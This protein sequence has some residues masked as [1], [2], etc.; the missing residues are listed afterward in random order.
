MKRNK[1]MTLFAACLM[2]ATVSAQ[3]TYTITGKSEGSGEK[4]ISNIFDD[5]INTKYC[6]NGGDGVYALLTASEP[7][8][9]W[10]YEMTTANDNE[11]YGRCIKKWSLFGTNDQAV[12]ADPNA[13]GW[14][15]LSDLGET[16]IVNQ[17]NYYTQRIFCEKGVN[18]P[19]KY[20]KVVLN[21]GN[22]IQLSE[23][24]IL[25]EVNRVV[26]Y[27]WK[28]SSQDNS[29]KAVDLLLNQKWEGSNIAGNWVTIETGDGQAYAVKSYSF[30]THDDG[31]CPGRAPKSWK[32]E[33]SNDNSNW[34]LIDEVVND[35]VI[36][37]ENYKTFDFTPANTTD[38]FR[39]IKL[40][41]NAMKGTGWTQ[42]GEFHV[43]STS[44]ISDAQYYTN[45]VNNAKATKTEY[46]TFMG[47]S[48]PWCVEYNTFFTG[49]NLDGELAAAISSGDYE[50]LEVKLKEAESNAIGQALKLFVNGANY[51]AI[52]GSECW[53]DGNYSQLFDN[54]E[55]TKWG[56]NNFPQYVIFRVKAAFKPFFYKLVTGNDT[57]NNTGRNWKSWNVYGANFATYK[58]ATNKDAEEWT[59]LDERTDVTEEYLPM[60]NFYP[61]TFDFNKGVNEDYLYYMVKVTAPHSGSQQQM[62]EMYL[63]TKEEFEAIRKPLVDELKEFATGVAD[64]VVESDLE[65][66]KKTFTDKFAELQTTSDAVAL[67]KLYNDLVALKE[68]IKESADFVAGGYRPISGNTEWGDGE[69]YTKLVDGDVETKWGGDMPEDGSSYVIFKA[70]AAKTF[71]QY[72]LITGNDTGDSPERNWKTWK[73]YGANFDSDDAATRDASWT[74]IDEKSDI[75]EDRLPAGNFVP[76]YFNISKEWT[77]N[78]KYFKIEVEEAADGGSIQMSEFKFL[79]DEAYAAYRQEYVD[80]LTKV[81]MALANLGEGIEIPEAVKNQLIAQL[82][83]T[84]GAMITEVATAT[85]DDLLPK[86]N[87]AIKFITVD[88]PALIQANVMTQVDGVYQIS[89]APQLVNFAVIVN[90]GATDAKAV[91]TTD[92]DLKDV[93]WT[94]IGNSSTKFEGTFDGQGHAITNFSYTSTSDGA[95]GFF[96]YVRNAT[97]KN[98]SISGTLTSDGGTKGNNFTGTIGAA[99]ANTVISGIYSSLS[100]NVSNCAAHSGGILGSTVTQG[101]PVLVEKCEYSGTLTHSGTGDCQA[102]ILGYTYDGGVKDCIFSGTIMGVSSK[103][104]GILG[105]CKIPSFLGVQNCLSV[106]K[107][108]AAEGCTTAAAIIANWNGNATKNVKNN[109]Y[110]LQEGSTT[111]IAIGNKTANCEAPVPVTADQLASNEVVLKL[112]V[113]FRQDVGKD[114]YPTLDAT[115][116][117]VI[118][119]SEAGYATLFIDNADLTIPEG[120]TASTG[121]ILGDFLKLNPIDGKIAAGEAVVLKGDAGVYSFAPTTGAVKAEN[122]D[123]KGAATDA[124]AAGKYVLAKP[125]GKAAGFYKA[126]E[127]TIKAGKAYIALDANTGP[128]VKAFLFE[129]EDATGINDLKDAKDLNNAVIYNVAGQRVNKL[130]KGINIV[131]GK[132]VLY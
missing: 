131:N 58:D 80:S 75:D 70:Y 7:V 78:Y 17:K 4:D 52:A 33:G 91:L 99:E 50:T 122:N 85:A 46:E 12:A 56:G 71:N 106:G 116:P 120:V 96:G 126:N 83:N 34:T 19:F 28:A 45:L 40:T 53:S 29:K 101:N 103:Y 64:M 98:F 39:Y 30:T 129:G 14:V 62:S 66:S 95:H 82:T 22:F 35:N 13:S 87:G 61:A 107:I 24:K 81:S 115:K 89:A 63:C 124:E 55:K 23:F 117:V 6:G 72:M 79:S 93:A 100:V 132:K 73:I 60:K 74:L 47:E 84:I 94:P 127:G 15:A 54:K 110:C 57:A 65:A 90:D 25:G 76:A 16:S 114:A 118:E 38:K 36:Q 1:L 97:I 109:Y 102:G 43:M 26:S 108:V 111:A 32:I 49:L 130:Q 68:A 11:K 41:L 121:L 105:Y 5:N 27:K 86:F 37:D 59:L 88:V 128:L 2:A 77:E 48:D 8:Y 18:K 125:E 67:T 44:D 3:V 42:V 21:D 112:G 10:A 69:N 9:V 31:N 119:I 123:L 104:G 92:I 113:A 20:F 51:S